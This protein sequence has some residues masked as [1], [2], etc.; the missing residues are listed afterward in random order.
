MNSASCWKS[1]CCKSAAASKA[2]AQPQT[3]GQSGVAAI[4]CLC[5][6][7]ED[8][9]HILVSALNRIISSRVMTRLQFDIFANYTEIMKDVKTAIYVYL[10]I[11]LIHFYINLL[12]NPDNQPNF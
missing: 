8:A 4:V 6:W 2:A 9:S 11:F 1:N 10:F 12:E 5:C 3:V 7:W